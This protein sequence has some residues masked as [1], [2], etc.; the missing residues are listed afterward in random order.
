MRPMLTLDASPA[1]ALTTGQ[2]LTSDYVA[3]CPM[4]II[5]AKAIASATA[6][7]S[8]TAQGS[9]QALGTGGFNTYTAALTMTTSGNISRASAITTAE[10]T[11]APTDV[12]RA[13]FV[14]GGGTGGANGNLYSEVVYLPVTGA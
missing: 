12:L 14:D 13:T 1:A 5:D 7:V 9:R 10:R 8:G 4:R 6:N 2:T 11:V 3:T